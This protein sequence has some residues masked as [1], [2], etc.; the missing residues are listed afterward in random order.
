MGP[1]GGGERLINMAVAVQT[2]RDK[3]LWLQHASKMTILAA[4]FKW[5]RKL[6]KFL[7]DNNEDL[8]VWNRSELLFVRIF[9]EPI[10][11]FVQE[12]FPE[13]VACDGHGIR[14]TNGVSDGYDHFRGHPLHFIS[15]SVSL[16]SLRR[17]RRCL[18]IKIVSRTS[19]QTACRLNL[20][21]S[22]FLLR[23]FALLASIMNTHRGWGPR[24]GKAAPRKHPATRWSDKASQFSHSPVERRIFLGIFLPSFCRFGLWPRVGKSFFKN[25]LPAFRCAVHELCHCG[26]I[27]YCDVTH[28]PIYERF[29]CVVH[30][31]MCTTFLLRCNKTAFVAM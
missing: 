23:C 20:C 16:S 29:F 11:I 27:L 31:T 30:L 19:K 13:R 21:A 14:L 7:R 9:I 10:R 17:S 22:T 26:S 8:E 4:R 15:N 28:Y 18:V 5:Y 3:E 24:N 12:T 1:L 6:D 25:F 2:T